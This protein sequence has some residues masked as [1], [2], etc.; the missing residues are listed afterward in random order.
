MHYDALNRL[1]REFGVARLVKNRQ[2]SSKFSSNP[3]S[4]NILF[5]LTILFAHPLEHPVRG[6]SGLADRL[7]ED[8]KVADVDLLHEQKVHLALFELFADDAPLAVRLPVDVALGVVPVREL[9]PH[10]AGQVELGV[11]FVDRHQLEGDGKVGPPV[12]AHRL[13]LALEHD[14]GVKGQRGRIP[15]GTVAPPVG[16]K[17]RCGSLLVGR[18][19]AGRLLL[20]AGG[21]Q[22]S[23][24]VPPVAVGQLSPMGKPS[25]SFLTHPEP[26]LVLQSLLGLDSF[27]V[28]TTTGANNTTT[29][30]VGSG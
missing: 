14:R 4:Q 29:M 22:R 16:R 18:T 25:G 8:G 1:Q 2:V 7:P 3:P 19:P 27:D 28:N 9:E 11:L 30:V 15:G 26:P 10:V 23:D 24:R 12:A 6:T 20:T 17:V 5:V 21:W 13:D